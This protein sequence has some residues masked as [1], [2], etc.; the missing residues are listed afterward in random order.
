MQRLTHFKQQKLAL[1]TLLI[2]N[3]FAITAIHAAESTTTPTDEWKFTLRN[4]YIDRDFD[5]AGIKD[6]GS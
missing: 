1:A 5:N 3:G 6:T 4:A 2:F